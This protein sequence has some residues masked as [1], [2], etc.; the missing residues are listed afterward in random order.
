[1]TSGNLS[2][3]P[4]AYR[5]QE[6]L[7]RLAGLADGWLVHD[8]EIAA[9]CDDSVVRVV[10]GAP[11]VMRRARGYVPRAIH[12]ST[13]V[14]RPVLGCGALLKNT[15]CLARG[16]RAWLGPHVGDLDNLATTTFFEEAV[17]RMER[18][19]RVTP[20][21]FAHDL[22]P[23]LHSTHYAQRR[24]GDAAVPVQHHHAHV[25]A[26]MAEH[27]LDGPVI[28]LAFDGTGH[29][30][31]G[32]S[33]GGEFLV[34][35]ATAFERV[36]TFR[37]VSL[38]GGDRAVHDVWRL[39]MAL[40]LD[41]FGRAAPLD[42]LPVIRD[43][44]PRERQVVEQMLARHL[45]VVRAHGL[46]RYFDAFGSMVLNRPWSSYEGQVAVEWNHA[47]AQSGVA[48]AYPYDLDSTGTCLQVDLRETTRAL[49]LDA[50][51]GVPAAVLS[52]RFHRTIVDSSV[53]V[54]RQAAAR[55]G[56]LPVVLGGGCFQNRLLTEGLVREL[57]P[58]FRVFVPREVPPGDGGLALGQ[59]LVASASV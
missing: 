8:R 56:P 46:G 2:E 27:G 20:E 37:P 59:V 38:A 40:L 19:T 42:A 55:H 54:V 47:A 44:D 14:P 41:A 35:D 15:F 49:V 30:P 33:W 11:M 34:A 28:G 26:V 39:A 23:D 57:A 9:P 50:I 17:E 10:A 51:E 5:D 52:S 25:A 18:F 48:G 24:A 16:D 36:A 3:Q 1:M 21:V 13:P 45:N 32:A 6:A 29:G 4:L 7:D 31:D 53:D 58:G 43:R 22:H 12:L